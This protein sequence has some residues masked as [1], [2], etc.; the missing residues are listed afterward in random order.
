MST[1]FN[2]NER[3]MTSEYVKIIE[4][5]LKEHCHWEGKLDIVHLDEG[6]AAPVWIDERP[7]E[8]VVWCNPDI[9]GNG[10]EEKEEGKKCLIQ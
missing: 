9:Y 7:K 5:K 4:S 10:E 8:Q 2:P 1:P 6:F 3:Q